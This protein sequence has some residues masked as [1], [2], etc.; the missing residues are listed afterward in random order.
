MNLAEN[1]LQQFKESGL[2]L[3]AIGNVDVVV[4]NLERKKEIVFDS[5]LER[6]ASGSV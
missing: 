6:L 1:N 3:H 4:A 2:L 5:V